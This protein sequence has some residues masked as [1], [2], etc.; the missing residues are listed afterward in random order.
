MFVA[1]VTAGV[2]VSRLILLLLFVAFVVV[3]AAAVSMD[4]SFYSLSLPFSPYGRCCCFQYRTTVSMSSDF[5]VVVAVVVAAAAAT[6]EPHCGIDVM[7]FDQSLSTVTA[8][9]TK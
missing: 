7:Y 6:I 2:V 5:A 4:S 1:F 8:A 3:V 9:V